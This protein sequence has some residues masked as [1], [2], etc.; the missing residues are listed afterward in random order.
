MTR[1]GPTNRM[2]QPDRS[3]AE[4]LNRGCDCAATDL[5][6]LRMSIE[7]DQGPAQSIL[8]THPHLFSRLPVFVDPA[9]V[10]QM[11]VVIDAVEA[12]VR[13]P[14]YQQAV[15]SYAPQVAREGAS[16]Y[17]ARC[18]QCHGDHG[19]GRGD[20]PAL[21]GGRGSLAGDEPVLTVGSYW[22]H[23]TT[24]FDYIRRAMPYQEP[25]VLS[26]DDVYSLTAWILAENGIVEPTAVLTEET[27]PNVEMPNRN[28]FESAVDV[29]Q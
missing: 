1:D 23:A 26:P 2:T 8:E 24:L 5:P 11:Q 14:T 4:L 15:L 19:E 18:A 9:D 17:A 16:L 29:Q 12:T 28:G 27:L 6:K 7:G 20:F 22:P 25:G 10:A 21:V 13:L 3:L